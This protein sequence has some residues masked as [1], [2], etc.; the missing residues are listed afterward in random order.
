MSNRP[1][2][3]MQLG[4]LQHCVAYAGKQGLSD[5][6]V[7]NAEAGIATMTFL[8]DNRDTFLLFHTIMRAFPGSV[9]EGAEDVGEVDRD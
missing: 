1:S 3:A 9:I 5:S 6:I 2:L 7:K 4:A 8:R